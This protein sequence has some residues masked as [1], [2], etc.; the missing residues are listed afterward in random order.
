[1]E[2]C[3]ADGGGTDAAISEII[4]ALPAIAE[5]LPINIKNGLKCRGGYG[6]M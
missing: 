4:A 5:L 6:K 2:R 3:A 1:M